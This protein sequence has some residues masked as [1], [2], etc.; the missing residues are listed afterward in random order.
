MIVQLYMYSFKKCTMIIDNCYN[1]PVYTSFSYRIDLGHSPFWVASGSYSAPPKLKEECSPKC[2]TGGG[3]RW[4]GVFCCASICTICNWN[5]LSSR[6]SWASSSICLS[7]FC[8]LLLQRIQHLI[9]I[10]LRFNHLF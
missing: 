7:H 3:G 8:P 5:S 9:A 2:G 6:L 1:V 10:L 4:R